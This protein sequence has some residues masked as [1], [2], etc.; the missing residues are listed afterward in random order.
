MR[1]IVAGRLRVGTAPTFF[2][3]AALDGRRFCGHIV[4]AAFKVAIAEKP[5][6]MF[7]IRNRTRVVQRHPKGDW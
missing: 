2:P 3:D 4:D 6:G 5:A 7:T 1:G